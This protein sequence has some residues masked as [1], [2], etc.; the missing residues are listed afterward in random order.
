METAIEQQELPFTTKGKFP[1]TRYQGSKQKFID[2]LWLC[3][4]DFNFD[5]VLDAFGGTGCFAYKAKQEGK[6]VTYNDLLPFN[7]LIGKALIENPGEQLS[8]K[9]LLQVLDLNS[10]VNA[11]TFISDTFHDIYYTDEENL[12]LD[13]V[14][15]NIRNM[16]NPYKQAMAYFALFQSCIIKRPYNLFHRKNLYAR[17]KE[18]K[19]SF[20][21]KTTWDRP[22]DQHFRRFVKEVNAASFDSGKR[23][24]SICCDAAEI[25]GKFDL[26]YL[27]PP[28]VGE[29]GKNV[30]YAE[31]YHFLNGLCNYQDWAQ[32]IDYESPHRRLK[33]V[34]SPWCD[35][36]R[37]AAEF[38]KVISKY[39]ESVL[40]VSYRSDGIPSVDQLADILRRHFKYLT[41]YESWNIK[42]ALSHNTS[43][44]VLFLARS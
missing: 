42:Y 26:V 30:D 10:A 32:L 24:K 8:E 25:E 12:W 6:F 14:S 20:G 1:S 34:D 3:V 35:K 5:S 4:R 29:S 40:A 16:Q 44:E 22:F 2:W 18:V 21:N 38:E 41:T 15:Y 23:C 43:Q 31:F 27:D 17:L 36:V 33:R 37:V 11:P 28:Y 13:K 7:C 19:R 39:E 9:E